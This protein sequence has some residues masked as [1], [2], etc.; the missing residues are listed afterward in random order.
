M[1]GVDAENAVFEC[2]HF[3][4]SPLI[5]SFLFGTQLLET[6]GYLQFHSSKIQNLRV[7]S[8]PANSLLMLPQY[9]LIGEPLEL[10]EGYFF[11]QDPW[12]TFSGR[13]RCIKPPFGFMRGQTLMA[14][15]TA[16]S[17]SLTTHFGSVPKSVYS[18]VNV[19]IA[20]DSSQS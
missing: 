16:N 10:P 6:S 18:E 19:A 3:S 8:N 12:T 5:G 4:N 9:K 14:V 7:T 2:C 15:F 1:R 17:D 11:E 20:P 13:R